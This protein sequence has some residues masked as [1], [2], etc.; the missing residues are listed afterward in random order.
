[1]KWNHSV[2]MSHWI[3][4]SITLVLYALDSCKSGY[5]DLH[6]PHLSLKSSLSSRSDLSLHI[7][8]F[9][10][11]WNFSPDAL[12]GRFEGN[13]FPVLFLVDP[14]FLPAVLT[15]CFPLQLT[16]LAVFVLLL[17]FYLSFLFLDLV[18]SFSLYS[19]WC[20][21]SVIAPPSVITRG[22]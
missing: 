14:S 4:L 18:S 5:L 20:S 7:S 8:F 21:L 9:K 11:C 10:F 16:L 19:A 2:H 6:T 22:L 1:M 17:F 3:H 12:C 13:C 15:F